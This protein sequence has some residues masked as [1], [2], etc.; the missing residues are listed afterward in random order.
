MQYA[1]AQAI[2][3]FQ[4]AGQMYRLGNFQP[5]NGIPSTVQY[6]DSKAMPAIER[7]PPNWNGYTEYNV[8]TRRGLKQAAKFDWAK[9]V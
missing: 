7:R 4:D 1:S 5:L 3:G 9:K 6:D 8:T 2:K